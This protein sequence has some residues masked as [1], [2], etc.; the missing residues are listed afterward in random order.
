MRALLAIVALILICSL[1]GWITFSKG[2]ERS[3]INIETDKIRTDS[4]KA[5]E[6]GATLLR[7]TGDKINE[8]VHQERPAPASPTGSAPAN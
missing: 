8:R 2:P 3:S 4:E 5:A 1:L 6:T 7:T